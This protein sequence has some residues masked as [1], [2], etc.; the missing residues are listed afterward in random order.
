MPHA[1][2]PSTTADSPGDQPR[3]PRSRALL[4]AGIAIAISVLA[5]PTAGATATLS[6]TGNT[7][8][9]TGDASAD[10]IT[11]TTGSVDGFVSFYAP[12]HTG[13]R[14]GAGCRRAADLDRSG[15]EYFAC[16]RTARPGNALT[17][18]A[19]LGA[20]DDELL[21]A[22]RTDRLP[23]IVA[24]GGEGNDRLHGSI[25][26]DDLTGGPGDDELDGNDGVDHLIGVAGDDELY[27]GADGDH[28]TGG[29]GRDL[30]NGGA[31]EG[32]TIIDATDAPTSLAGLSP[33]EIAAIGPEV[34]TVVCSSGPEDVATVDAA[35][36][37]D[38]NCESRVGANPTPSRLLVAQY[39]FAQV[40]VPGAVIAV[41]A[42]VR[43]EAIRFAVTP[44]TQ[45]TIDAKLEVSATDA[46]RY[47]LKNRA[48]A[49]T[50]PVLVQATVTGEMVLRL[51][52]ADRAP[53]RGRHDVR[54]TLTVRAS[55]PADAAGTRTE[56]TQATKPIV[57][58]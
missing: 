15:H 46:R 35:D 16:G 6:R 30:L 7:L 13:I 48:I 34:D 33:E 31:P 2:S 56:T 26:S 25:L 44:S 11:M 50:R 18:R 8:T 47:G 4:M 38:P 22:Y 58:R 55:H 28:L 21:A 51:D 36:L 57:L 3:A 39:P 23:R 10:R 54:A 43:G 20:G 17:L 37:V 12:T 45:A 52:D 40:V 14:T 41:N 5:A 53:L 32:N 24:D 27:G 42:A 1:P 29:Q 19:N 49:A 9:L